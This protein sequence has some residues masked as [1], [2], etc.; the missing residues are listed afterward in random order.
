MKTESSSAIGARI[1][2]LRKV[3]NMTME[4]FAARLGVTKGMVSLWEANKNI[5]HKK[6]AALI[7]KI[8]D[9]NLKWLFT[10]TGW[11]YNFSTAHNLVDWFIRFVN[12]HEIKKVRILKYIDNKA[13][14]LYPNGF[15]LMFKDRGKE[16]IISIAGDYTRST[17]L[18]GCPTNEY[19]E[20][21]ISLKVKK[22]NPYMLNMAVRTPADIEFL[23]K[24]DLTKL[25]E[26]PED[27]ANINKI[28]NLKNIAPEEAILLLESYV[29]VIDRELYFL[30]D[31]ELA[32]N[33]D[34]SIPE[35]IKLYSVLDE[36]NK[37]D[38]L[39]LLRAKKESKDILE[40][41]RKE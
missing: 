29:G 34:S 24:D 21:L 22:V 33:I 6:T 31:I 3:E 40:R 10:G 9:I 25:I 8:F 16:F 37:K 5:P 30:D 28:K 12:N 2:I 15:I 18:G 23:E 26:L 19:R 27:N 13:P 1:Y 14:L 11:M 39:N 20:I 17:S 32:S 35:L 4:S 41:L 38:F 36:N 7:T